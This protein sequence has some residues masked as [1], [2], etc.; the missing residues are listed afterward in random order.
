[1]PV[2]QELVSM[3][4]P[5]ADREP[6]P[7]GRPGPGAAGSVPDFGQVTA[8]WLTLV[9]GVPGNSKRVWYQLAWL[10]CAR[11]EKESQTL[12]GQGHFSKEGGQKG[13][14]GGHGWASRGPQPTEGTGFPN[15][16]LGESGAVGPLHALPSDTSRPVSQ[17]HHGLAPT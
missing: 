10:S 2:S 15:F 7:G 4:H 8:F 14:K 12:Q 1:M 3:A 11:W 9:S 13:G 17:L 16:P 5:R 6:R